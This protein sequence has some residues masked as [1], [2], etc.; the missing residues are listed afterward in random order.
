MN[1]TGY[2]HPESRAPRAELGGQARIRSMPVQVVN[3][4]ERGVLVEA[5]VSFPH[6]SRL[7]VSLTIGRASLSC[8]GE[9]VRCF[10]SG[11]SRDGARGGLLYRTGIAFNE[12]ASA[13]RDALRALVRSVHA[14]A[15]EN[16]V[17]SGFGG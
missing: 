14:S 16:A 17:M 9:V 15:G 13:D 2:E 6:G 12:L 10:V 5:E 4:S 3:V 1:E 7:P 8:R 11:V